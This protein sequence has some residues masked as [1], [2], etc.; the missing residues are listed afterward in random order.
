[1]FQNTFAPEGASRCRALTSDLQGRAAGRK[2]TLSEKCA[3]FTGDAGAKSRKVLVKG[4][5]DL[6]LTPS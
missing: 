1:M 5:R 4:P 2:E 3:R 6:K